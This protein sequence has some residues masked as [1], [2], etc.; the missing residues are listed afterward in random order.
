MAMSNQDLIGG[1]QRYQP[2]NPNVMSLDQYKDNIEPHN[3]S[4]ASIALRGNMGNK[5]FHGSNNASGSIQQIED[6]LMMPSMDQKQFT[7]YIEDQDSP[8]ISNR[9][10]GTEVFKQ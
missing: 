7:S 2:K 5:K 8:E 4:L 6:S 10:E 3:K 9:L 1:N